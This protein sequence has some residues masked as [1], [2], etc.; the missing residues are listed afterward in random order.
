MENEVHI[1]LRLQKLH[2]YVIHRNSELLS[3]PVAAAP[4][5]SCNYMARVNMSRLKAQ[6]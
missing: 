2:E 5:A 1:G 4:G 3:G 6:N